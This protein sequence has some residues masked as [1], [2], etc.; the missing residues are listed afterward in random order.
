MTPDAVCKAIRESE[1]QFDQ[2]I[3]EF[4]S[5]THISVTNNANDTPRNQMLVIDNSGTRAFR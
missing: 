4:D 2:L 1:I 3:K 5:W